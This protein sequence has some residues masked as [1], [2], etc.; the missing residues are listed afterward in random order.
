MVYKKK[1]V[2]KALKEQVWINTF[3]KKFKNKCYVDWCN[4]E[5]NVFNYHVGHDIPESK[6]GELKLKNLKPICDRCNYSMS[7]NY[8]IKRWNKLVYM[9]RCAIL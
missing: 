3:G 8:T 2:P 9:R 6:G 1:N 5:I 7:N 4:N